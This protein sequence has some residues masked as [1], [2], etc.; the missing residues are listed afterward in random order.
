MVTNNTDGSA[1]SQTVPN[2]STIL[3]LSNNQCINAWIAFTVLRVW[4]KTCSN[5]GYTPFNKHSWLENGPWFK[6]IRPLQNEFISSHFGFL[7]SPSSNQKSLQNCEFHKKSFT[8]S[9]GQRDPCHPM[10]TKKHRHAP[11]SFRDRYRRRRFC[12]NPSKEKPPED[13]ADVG[14]WPVTS[15][16]QKSGETWFRQENQ[17]LFGIQWTLEPYWNLYGFQLVIFTLFWQ[18]NILKQII[19]HQPKG[20]LFIL[21]REILDYLCRN[22]MLLAPGSWLI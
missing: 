20:S 8:N 11:S 18:I 15:L 9:P 22:A 4:K 2:P 16:S 10:K 13:V 1:I 12:P 19:I 21:K 5:W 17:R 6:M 14:G 7:K 3:P